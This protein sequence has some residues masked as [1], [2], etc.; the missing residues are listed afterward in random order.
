MSSISLTKLFF[1]YSL[2]LTS[3][4]QHVVEKKP[5]P[6]PKPVAAPVEVKEFFEY[7]FT[8]TLSFEVNTDPSNSETSTDPSGVK[9]S[10]DPKNATLKPSE[11]TTETHVLDL[12][13][14][15]IG[16]K[17]SQVAGSFNYNQHNYSLSGVREDELLRIRIRPEKNSGSIEENTKKIQGVGLLTYQ[18]NTIDTAKIGNIEGQLQ[19]GR[20]DAKW[21]ATARAT[22]KPLLSSPKQSN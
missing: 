2:I 16:Q 21:K 5:T 11:E 7:P 15:L 17:H 12:S 22:L 20:G 3:C 6:Q 10:A 18:P 8:G 19:L 1:F 13:L 4:E 9:P 14:K